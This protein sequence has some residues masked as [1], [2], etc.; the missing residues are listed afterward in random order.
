MPLVGLRYSTLMSP[1]KFKL[2]FYPATV[3]ESAAINDNH[4]NNTTNTN[5]IL[6]YT[7]LSANNM[8]GVSYLGPAMAEAFY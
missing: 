1:P 4:D 5:S 7:T 8:L 3:I 2:L 6:R